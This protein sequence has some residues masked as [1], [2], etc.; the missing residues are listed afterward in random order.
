[1]SANNLITA[2]VFSAFLKCPTKA[3]LLVIGEPNPGTFFADIEMCIS[4]M[5]RAAAQRRLCAE[6]EFAQPLNFGQLDYSRNHEGVLRYVDCR[7]T[8]YDLAL[9][10]YMPGDHRSQNPSP[11]KTI[12]P[13]LFLPWDKPEVSDSLLVCFGALALSQAL[14]RSHILLVDRDL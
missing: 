6:T 11:S 8:V 4:S 10:P 5:Y 14:R 3:H 12:L 9:P 1:M 7:T 13:I 2:A